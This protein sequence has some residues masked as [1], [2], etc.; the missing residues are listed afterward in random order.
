MRAFLLLL[1][2]P[3]LSCA[4][5]YRTDYEKSHDVVLSA[6]QIEDRAELRSLRK[7][8]IRQAS[9]NLMLRESLGRCHN[10]N[11]TATCLQQ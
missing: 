6:E 5:D 1:L 9:R 10:N 11:D 4:V 3:L 2:L 8:A 7:K